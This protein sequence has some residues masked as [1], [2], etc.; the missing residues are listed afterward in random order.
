MHMI[1]VSKAEC[2]VYIVNLV[3]SAVQSGRKLQRDNLSLFVSSP[4]ANSFEGQ[5]VSRR[6]GIKHCPIFDAIFLV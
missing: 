4:E 5:N 1:L 6:A 2:L 3:T